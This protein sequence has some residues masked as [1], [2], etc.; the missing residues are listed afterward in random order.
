MTRYPVKE[1]LVGAYLATG[2]GAVCERLEQ[3]GGTALGVVYAAMYLFLAACLLGAAYVRNAYVRLSYAVVLMAAATFFDSYTRIVADFMRYDTF[4]TMLQSRS[5]LGDALRQHHRDIAIALMQGA[6]LFAAILL[7]P[8]RRMPG[9]GWLHV[10]AVPMGVALLTALLFVRAGDGAKGLPPMFVTLAYANLYAYEAA[11]HDVGERE[12]VAIAHAGTPATRDLVLII[13]ESVS[14]NYLDLNAAHGV[15]TSL[16]SPPPGV[17]VHNF[18]YAA[19][20]THCSE[21]TNVGLRYG[22]T[23]SDYRRM[24]STMPSIWQYALHAGYSTVYI[25]AQ[26]VDGAL[27]NQM[28]REELLDV[29]HF[30]QFAGVAPVDRDMAAADAIARHLAN[31]RAELIVVNKVGAHFPVHDKYPDEFMAYKPALRRGGWTRVT[32][33]GAS[34]VVETEDWTV[35][36]NSYRNTLLYNVGGFFTRLF[37]NAPFERAT[38]I[39]TS[40]HG[41]NLH[42]RGEPGRGTHCRPNPAMEE[43]LVPLVVI[44]GAAT[45]TRRWDQAVATNRDRASHYNIFPTM[46]TL[47]GYDT[48][49]VMDVY[50]TPLTAPVGD[51]LSFNYRYEARLGVKPAWRRIDLQQIVTP[52]PGSEQPPLAARPAVQR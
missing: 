47:M 21:G 27:H 51:E 31:D 49:S 37:A 36:R 2:A 32:D 23:R 14:A 42:E 6:L 45:P 29:N 44:E 48:A 39:Y 52:P 34:G 46:L 7:E 43:G 1:F 12:P 15:A 24:I 8:K 40:D 3:L 22:G 30:V 35:Y 4:A 33:I 41:Q 28:T 5:S 50:G 38:V 26:R 18:G 16:R 17:G 11:R 10:A 9:P 20:I 19:S 25:D 13:D